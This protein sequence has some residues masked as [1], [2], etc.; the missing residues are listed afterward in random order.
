MNCYIVNISRVRVG[1]VEFHFELGDP[2]LLLDM[3]LPLA[4]FESF[5]GDRGIDP[6]TGGVGRQYDIDPDFGTGS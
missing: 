3:V 1:L 4:A 2:D 6:Q 5:C